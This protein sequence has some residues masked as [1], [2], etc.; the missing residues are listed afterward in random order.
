MEV[1]DYYAYKTGIKPFSSTAPER[2]IFFPKNFSFIEEPDDA[3]VVLNDLVKF[4]LGGHTRRISIHQEKCV[5]IDHCAEAAATALAIQAHGWPRVRF[6]GTFP[7]SAEQRD[8]VL[9]TGLPSRL[10]IR[11]SEPDGFLKFPLKHARRVRGTAER[12]SEKEVQAT[13]ITQYVDE[14]LDGYGWELT[15]DAKGYL[16]SLV[17]EVL[18]NAEEHSQRPDWWMAGYLRQK[19]KTYGDCHI[20]IFNFGQTL[21]ESL[22][23]LPPDSMLRNDIEELVELHKKK[24]YFSL[25]GWTEENL[26][27]LYALQAGVSR[28]NTG[29]D[30]LGGFARGYGTVKMI[31]FFQEI[32]KSDIAGEPPK[33]CIVSGR[34]HILFDGKYEMRSQKTRRGE[35][36]E[37]I[38][39]NKKN[40]LREKPDDKYVRHL[41]HP[42]PG[43]LISLRFYFDPENLEKLGEAS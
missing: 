31:Q 32:G 25:G 11:L 13:K 10:G 22:Q 21:A 6:M 28:F 12:S 8:I 19:S 43:T 24:K 26:W 18:D 33:M 23:E 15:D 29:R 2:D 30:N 38:A 4:S 42:F 3:L 34:T 17:G 7:E 1:L 27:T 35:D 37:I 36:A 14:C 40:D 16:T 5:L 20:T 41:R 9:A 39:F